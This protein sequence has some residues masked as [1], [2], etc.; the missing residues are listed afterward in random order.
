MSQRIHE[1]RT[2]RAPERTPPGQLRLARQDE[3]DLLVR[4]RADFLTDIGD[5]GDPRE[6]AATRIAGSHLF[7]RDHDGNT[8]CCR[9]TDLANPTSNG[10]ART[11]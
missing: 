3:L 11:T 5:S 10:I 2:V 1:I 4:W 7:V 8:F 9:P 6:L